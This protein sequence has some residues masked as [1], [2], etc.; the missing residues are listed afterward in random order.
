[1]GPEV[2]QREIRGT[3]GRLRRN[4]A[5]AFRDVGHPEDLCEPKHRYDARLE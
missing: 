1:L 5:Q 4:K 3:L 2:E